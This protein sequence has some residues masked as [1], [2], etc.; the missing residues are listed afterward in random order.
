MKLWLLRHAQPQVREGVCYGATD[1]PADPAA[2]QRAA[3]EAAALLPSRLAVRASPLRRCRGLAQAL[4]ALRPDLAALEDARL[5]EMD[6]GRWE[7]QPWSAVPPSDYAAWTADFPGYRC[8]GGECV[9]G[10][11]E[12]VAAALDETRREG[13]DALWITHAGVMRAVRLLAVEGRGPARA[14]QWPSDAV[15]YGAAVCLAVPP[16]PRA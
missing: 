7:G 14:D 3:T 8:G 1:V 4:E 10:L 2:T 5:A 11:M 16:E 13:R 6:F 12:R 9:S 15:A